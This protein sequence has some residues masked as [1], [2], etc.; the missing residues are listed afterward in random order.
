MT[1]FPQLLSRF[2]SPLYVYRLESVRDALHDLRS[3]LPAP[4]RLYYSLKA[5]PHPVLAAELRLG[6]ACAEVSS[7]GELAAARQAGFAGE[8][9]LYTGPAKSLEEIAVAVAAGVR[10][11]SVE[12]ALD[13]HRVA[14]VSAEHGG[15][16]DCL[17][18]INAASAGASSLRMSSGSQFGVDAAEVFRAPNRF[19]DIDGARVIGA[20]LFSLSNAHDEKALITEITASVVLARRLRDE[21]G[22]RMSFVDLGGGFAAPHAQP[23]SR[24]RYPGLRA[25]LEQ[26]LDEHLAGWR[27]GHPAIAFESGRHLV[28]ESGSL[29]CTTVE[30]KHDKNGVFVLLDSGINHLGGMAGLGRLLRPTATPAPALGL[31]PGGGDERATIVGPLCTPADVLG[32]NVPVGQVK[33]GDV[34]VFPNVGAYGLTASLLGF[35]SRP[36]PVEVVMDEGDIVAASRV[37]LGRTP[38]DLG[39]PVPATRF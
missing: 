25:A 10:L 17:V 22:L 24:A 39:H 3:V 15:T 28:A 19:S 16:A 8:D 2:G 6:G 38:I 13:F 20:H 29:V 5:N 26:A 37:E 12:S 18:R 21:A 11:F 31:E 9:F 14:A 34:V 32:R 30:V 35:L 7:T 4:S 23:G 36:A 27:L 1:D 33:P